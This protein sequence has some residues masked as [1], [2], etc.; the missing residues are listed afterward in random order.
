MVSLK[1][2]ES[3]FEDL[4]D[5]PGDTRAELIDG[6]IYM[7][8]PALARHSL[9]NGVLTFRISAYLDDKRKKG[10]QGGD[11]DSWLIIPEAWVF[12]DRHNTFVHDIAG[13]LEKELPS[14]PVS[15]PITVRPMWVCETLSPSNWDNDTER[16]R[17][18]LEEH[19][20][21]YYWLVDPDRKTIQVFEMREN[22]EKYQSVYSVSVK[23]G[24]VKLPPFVELELDLAE[25][26][27]R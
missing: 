14:F 3:T 27:K 2:R 20:V 10:P 26:F 25:V 9:I 21:P 7:M 15:G 5:L 13:Y 8:A 6:V 1:H 4:M 11:S 22:T 24:I 17:V 23:D 18:I 16:K 19:Q 12:Y